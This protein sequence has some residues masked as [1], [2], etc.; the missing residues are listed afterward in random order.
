M[1]VSKGNLRGRKILT[2]LFSATQEVAGFCLFIEHVREKTAYYPGKGGGA[3]AW[4]AGKGK[5][6]QQTLSTQMGNGKRMV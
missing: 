5:E 1:S 3:G 2:P 4:D 6:H